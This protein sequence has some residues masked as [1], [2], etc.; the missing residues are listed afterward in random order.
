[1]RPRKIPCE[2]CGTPLVDPIEEAFNIAFIAHL[3][4]SDN[5]MELFSYGMNNLRNELSVRLGQRPT[6]D[7]L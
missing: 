2:Y 6:A 7:G 3:R 4:A 5:C 1:M